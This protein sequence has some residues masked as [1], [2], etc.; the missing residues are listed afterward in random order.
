MLLLRGAPD[1]RLFPNLLNGVGGH[2]ERGESPVEAA[3]REMLEETGIATGTDLRLAASITV[4][5][6]DEA[7]GVQIF[8]FLTTI[9]H[10]T[11]RPSSEGA[12]E[13]HTLTG[14]LSE[15]LVPD[16]YSLLPLLLSE[17]SSPAPYF[18]TYRYDEAG[19]LTM[20]NS[21]QD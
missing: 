17:S 18:L 6:G 21:T 4:D 19:R 10:Q 3:R 11:G 2:I 1:K 9:D 16:L 7:P 14:A 12:L 13:W 5:T 20:H 8:V 15:T